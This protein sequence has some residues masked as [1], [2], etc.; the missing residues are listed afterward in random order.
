MFFDDE[1]VISLR[2]ETSDQKLFDPKLNRIVQCTTQRRAKMW[3][4]SLRVDLPLAL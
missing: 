2:T 1:P 4:A 3:S